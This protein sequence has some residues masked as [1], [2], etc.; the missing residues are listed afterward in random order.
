MKY[1]D[2][3]KFALPEH[4]D[5]A[6]IETINNNFSM[7]DEEMKSLADK[8]IEVDGNVV[9]GTYTGDGQ[10]VQQINLGFTPAAIEVYHYTGMQIYH[11]GARYV[12]YGGLALENAPCNAVEITANGFKVTYAENSNYN[13]WSNLSGTSYYF[14]AYKKANVMVTE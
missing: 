11:N 14:K 9:F 8:I 3:F 10:A 4:S 7:V 5:A 6:D 12:C 1:T 2:N 13:Y